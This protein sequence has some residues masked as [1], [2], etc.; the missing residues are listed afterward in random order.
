MLGAPAAG[1]LN[2]TSSCDIL[3]RLNGS[4]PKPRKSLAWYGEGIV[5][6][7]N[8]MGLCCSCKL[9]GICS[10]KDSAKGAA[11]LMTSLSLLPVAC[12]GRDTGYQSLLYSQAVFLATQR[13]QFGTVLSHRRLDWTQARHAFRRDG[14]MTTHHFH[15]IQG[16][17]VSFRPIFDR[18]RGFVMRKLRRGKKESEK[19]CE[20]CCGVWVVVCMDVGTSV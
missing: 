17:R 16:K 9:L 5:K 10:A 14:G 11:K 19:A 6:P 18:L 15:Q 3:A 4:I 2:T 12:C 1:E 7:G 8:S 13:R 20:V